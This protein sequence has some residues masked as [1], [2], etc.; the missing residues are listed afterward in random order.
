MIMTNVV[1]M[2]IQ[3]G[4]YGAI[5]SMASLFLLSP[6]DEVCLDAS[7]ASNSLNCVASFEMY[8][9]CALTWMYMYM[10]SVFYTNQGWF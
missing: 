5:H 8:L 1:V 4:I 7:N 10:L 9:C 6:L 3:S 2:Y